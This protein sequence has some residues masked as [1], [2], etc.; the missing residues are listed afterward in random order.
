MKQTQLPLLSC[1]LTR[2]SLLPHPNRVLIQYEAL[3]R[4]QP[5]ASVVLLDLPVARIV[6]S[7]DKLPL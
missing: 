3:T 5:D 7:Q 1:A 4:R 6:G 2:S